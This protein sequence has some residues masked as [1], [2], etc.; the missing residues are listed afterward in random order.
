MAPLPTIPQQLLE[1][2]LAPPLSGRSEVSRP[3]LI[4]WLNSVGQAKLILI[5]APAG[6][7]K[8]TLMAQW[9]DDHREKE[10]PAAWLTL[11]EG[12]DDPARFL[13]DLIAAVEKSLPRS[14][15]G[16]AP[17]PIS[18]EHN[19]T[20]LL[21]YLLERLSALETSFTL[22]LDDFGVIKSAES[23]KPIQQLLQQLPPDKRLVMTSRHL[24]KLKLGRL[25]AQGGLAEID[26]EG[27]RFSL[28]E[29]REF[30]RRADNLE[31]DETEIA[32]LYHST[33]GWVA[34]LQLST[35]S[36]TWREKEGRFEK[37]SLLAIDNISEYLAEDVLS[38]Q[39]EDVQS[40]LI[41]TSMLQS[42]SASLCDA[43]T[44]QGGSAEML[45]HLERENLFI[46]PLDENRHWYRYHSLFARFLQ[47]R[48]E[49]RGEECLLDLH[50]AASRWYAGAGY[51]REA[52][53]HSMLAKDQDCAAQLIEQC[54]F[55]LLAAG[56]MDT[57]VEWGERLAGEVLDR[58]RVL[59]LAYALA[60]V[61]RQQYER[62][63]QIYQRLVAG[64]GYS[65]DEADFVTDLCITRLLI[66]IAQD[67]PGEAEKVLAEAVSAD[68]EVKGAANSRF[69][70][71]I[72]NIAC[73]LNI[74][75][76]R[77]E[78]ARKYLRTSMRY[79]NILPDSMV[80]LFYSSCF[81]AI[82]CL[83]QG[84]V[85]EVLELAGARLAN[86]SG[87]LKYSTGATVLAVVEAAALYEINEIDRAEKLLLA[88]AD[89]LPTA[90][91]TD[92]MMMGTLTLA[93][94][95]FVHG[96]QSGALRLLGQLERFGHERGIPRAVATS[97]QEQIRLLLHSGRIEQALG[98]CKNY[99]DEAV[100]E[101]FKG[102]SM[103]ANF[104]ETP[105]VTA[106]RLL[107]GEKRYPEAAASLRGEL[108]RAQE[109]GNQRLS[110]LLRI[111]LARVLEAEGETAAALR[112]LQE[113]LNDARA[114]G[115]MRC[116]LDE[117]EPVIRLVRELRKR[118]VSEA[119]GEKGGLSL[120]FLDRLLKASDGAVGSSSAAGFEPEALRL[121][122]L[123]EREK[124]IMVKL[125]LGYSNKQ[126]ADCL[127]ISVYT[128]QY[129]LRN[130]Y[131]KLGV[132]NRGQAVALA[133]SYGLID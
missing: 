74:I 106:V 56:Q 94:I 67:N 109:R 32:S 65:G 10:L 11:D 123:T 37:T 5:R 33:E 93:R 114:E 45:E 36:S 59:Q 22:F 130:I 35:L 116:F 46:S 97:H 48:L 38:G 112:L 21:L 23:L 120:D 9:F 110:L 76:E 19:P 78:L 103:I 6:F 132:N 3:R 41:R 44:G 129:H 92:L 113:A 96:D 39:A 117:G 85:R 104:P 119:P 49:R 121:D 26:L 87:V 13:A 91:P 52:A 12:D 42:L 24:P 69:L 111:L 57:V 127:F 126:L 89:L 31:L 61:Y 79:S 34:G 51:L 95:R 105:Q 17:D 75:T 50:R 1:S 100:W 90:G 125:A 70:P 25:R 80:H 131:S 71:A 62:A 18:H 16:S 84:R 102:R 55:R 77:Y 81:E 72:F 88:Y 107:I 2:K 7:G 108:Q 64:I 15:A 30:I 14:A 73:Y 101:P 54:S 4:E 86:A 98:F 63:Q 8:T 115:L 82:I 60:L 68:L 43:V 29:T 58:H 118:L 47:K 83:R 40:F 99:D 28:D 128:V 27:L 124:E 66:L 53:N 133:R 122:P 20:G